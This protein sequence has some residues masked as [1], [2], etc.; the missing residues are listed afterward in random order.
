M[1]D[2]NAY[3]PIPPTI[4]QLSKL[5][6]L[7]SDQST[8]AR[9]RGLQ[10]HGFMMTVPFRSIGGTALTKKGVAYAR[11]ILSRGDIEEYM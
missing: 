8:Q 6:N 11:Y 1:E 10:E 9:V 2:Q 7:K 4:A 5:L 3:Y